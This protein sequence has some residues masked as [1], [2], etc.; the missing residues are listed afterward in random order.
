MD[1]LDRKLL[2][3]EEALWEV[4]GR[5]ADGLLTNQDVE[6]EYGP[7]WLWAFRVILS[8]GVE[9]AKVLLNDMVLWQDGQHEASGG[10]RRQS[11]EGN[12]APMEGSDEKED[13][14]ETHP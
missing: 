13:Q 4:Y 1:W 9:A 11:A 12:V 7:Q 6:H 5:W 2:V 8:E 10:G 14:H 3:P